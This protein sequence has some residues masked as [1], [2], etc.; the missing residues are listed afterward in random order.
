MQRFLGFFGETPVVT[1]TAAPPGRV[2]MV[3]QG[4]L[5]MPPDVQAAIEQGKADG[6]KPQLSSAALF[7]G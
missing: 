1:D 2:Y 3:Q 6:F 7:H 5:V 4:D